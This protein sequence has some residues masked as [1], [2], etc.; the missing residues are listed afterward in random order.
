VAM[1][2]CKVSSGF[3][4]HSSAFAMP[5]KIAKNYFTDLFLVHMVIPL[6]KLFKS[7]LQEPQISL[8]KKLTNL[9]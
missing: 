7:H 1:V 5:E 2:N 9:N 4:T 8:Q 3:I 6:F